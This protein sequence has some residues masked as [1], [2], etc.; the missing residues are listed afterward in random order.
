MLKSAF[1]RLQI[2]QRVIAGDGLDAPHPGSH[3][4]LGHDLEQADVARS[5]HVRAPAQLAA[6]ADIEHPDLIAVLLAKQHHRAGLLGFF[7]RQHSRERCDVRQNFSVDQCLDLSDLGLAH[8]GVVRKVETGPL[9]IH[10]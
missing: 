6:A 10:E 9:G 2:A 1:D 4:A 7:K 8:R 5:L 3:T